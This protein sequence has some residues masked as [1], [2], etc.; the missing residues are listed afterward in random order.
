MSRQAFENQTRVCIVQMRPTGGAVQLGFPCT[1]CFARKQRNVMFFQQPGCQ[2]LTHHLPSAGRRERRNLTMQ[3][4]DFSHKHFGTTLKMYRIS[5]PM[6]DRLNLKS[7]TQ[8]SRR[9]EAPDDK[10]IRDLA[11]DNCM[12]PSRS[13]SSLRA[14]ATRMTTDAGQHRLAFR[15]ADRSAT[16]S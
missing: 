3:T 9:S 16:R 11:L 8:V 6:Q 4:P 7:C 5:L 13:R 2:M 12:S 15:L 10:R 14:F 1:G